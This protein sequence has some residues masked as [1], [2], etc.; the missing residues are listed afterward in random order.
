MKSEKEFTLFDQIVGQERA[1]NYLKE[2]V[3]R[4]SFSHAYI[5]YGPIGSGKKLAALSFIAV[6]NCPKKGCGICD[7]CKQIMN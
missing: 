6:L 5:F 7:S 2:I 4:R 1:L 3:I